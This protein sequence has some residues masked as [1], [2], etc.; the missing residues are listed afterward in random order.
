MDDNV[1]AR[2]LLNE[3]E[4]PAALR[5]LILPGRPSDPIRG[6]RRRLAPAHNAPPRGQ[7]EP[8]KE[9]AEKMVNDTGLEPVTSGFEARQGVLSASE[10]LRSERERHTVAAD[11]H[12]ERVPR[13][14]A[15]RWYGPGTVSMPRGSP[16][17]VAPCV[18]C[19]HLSPIDGAS[20][21]P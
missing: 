2:Q 8:T 17:A 12:A 3:R 13:S 18:Y 4:R 21:R 9:K 20:E 10:S 1:P 14:A 15:S 7:D 16:C 19:L 6:D 11:G 5:L